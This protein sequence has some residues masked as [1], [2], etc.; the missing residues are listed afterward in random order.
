MP[1]PGVET[2]PAESGGPQ[3]GTGPS[4][5]LEPGER[6]ADLDEIYLDG[7][8]VLIGCGQAKRD[9]DNETDLHL[10]AVGEDEQIRM[11]GPTGPAWEARDL[12]TSSYFSAKR[13]LAETVTGW[14]NDY[15]ASPWGII[16]AKHNILQPWELVTPYDTSI[17]DLGGDETNPD[18]W[19]DVDYPPRRPDGREI[20]TEKDY[21]A[22]MT[23]FDLAKWVSS[24]REMGARP[25]QNDA[26]SLLV[27]A[28][29]DYVD[30]LR[31]R[32]VF[33]YGISRMTGDP[34]EGTKMPLNTRFLFE[35]IE[36][37]GIHDQMSWL[38]D[39]I[40]R[41]DDSV[42]ETEQVELADWTGAD[43]NCLECGVSGREGNLTDYDG[44]VYCNEH[45]PLGRCAR[46]KEFTHST[47]HGT[48]PLCPDCQTERGGMKNEPLEA[49]GT[50]QQSMVM[51][52]GGA[53]DA[54]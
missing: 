25:G 50:E 40:D 31:D 38:S 14:A 22:A 17:K 23:A 12:Y 52:E 27:V 48:Y 16:S 36:Q 44:E 34:N 47:G 3:A 7:T 4:I 5:D 6:V 15:D 21:W 13:E 8:L 42:A 18:H 37:D 33:E 30:A 24:F 1:E 10:A 2:G 45:Q 46:C 26:N 51:T 41:I 20:V 43:R 54:E 28:G 35:E 11:H 39:A 19:V 32:G 49:E 29:Q 53:G 9:P